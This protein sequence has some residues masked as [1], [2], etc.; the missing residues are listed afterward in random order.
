[1][2]EIP[3][4][5][6]RVIESY[7]NLLNYNGIPVQSLFLYGSYAKGEQSEYSDIDIALISEIF[8]GKRIPDRS[9]IRKLTLSVSS[10]L[11][12][13]PFNPKDFNMGNPFA[14]EIMESGIKIV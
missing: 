7:V 2:V 12:V 11:E 1:M 3:D 9:K 14:R 8:E 10:D 13:M 5:I 6:K 4:K